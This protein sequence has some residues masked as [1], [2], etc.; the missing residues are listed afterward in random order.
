MH[1]ETYQRLQLTYYPLANQAFGV[2]DPAID[3]MTRELKA[4]IRTAK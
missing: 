3:K 2:M 4:L 1:L